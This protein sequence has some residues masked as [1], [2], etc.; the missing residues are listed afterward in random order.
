M[1]A[2]P[3]SP[4]PN[5]TGETLSNRLSSE[6][7]GFIVEVQGE[8]AARKF[9]RQHSGTSP[10]GICRHPQQYHTREFGEPQETTRASGSRATIRIFGWSGA[11]QGLA[12]ACNSDTGACRGHIDDRRR[13]CEELRTHKHYICDDRVKATNTV[14]YLGTR[15]S[16]R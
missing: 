12:I 2:E 6:S 4:P 11:D 7:V 8:A 16:Q 3:P 14:D 1:F 9:V 15:A 13:Y 10:F 5:Q